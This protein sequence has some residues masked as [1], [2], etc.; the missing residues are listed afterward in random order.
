VSTVRTD[1]DRVPT[2]GGAT[3]EELLEAGRRTLEVEVR[4]LASLREGLG[5]DFLAAVDLL[6]G[7]A[8]RV[9]CTGMGKSGIIAHKLAATLASTGTPALFLHPAEAVHGDLGMITPQDAVLAISNSGETEEVLRMLPVL[10]VMA[11]P[12]V[13]MSSRPESS[14]GRAAE[15][16]LAIPLQEEG[17]PIGLAPMAS[18]TA[19]LALGD[20]L[21]AGLMKR[22]GFQPSDFALFHP[23]GH[24]GRRLLTRVRDLMHPL[25]GEVPAISPATPF[26][27]A[28]E[29]MITSN[30]GA[31][32]VVDEQGAL[33]GLLTDG[34]IK[35]VYQRLGGDQETTVAQ[36]MTRSPTVVGPE[37]M[38]ERAL[39]IMEDRPRQ[40]TVLPVVG[41]DRRALGL[42][43]LHDILRAKIK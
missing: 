43:R 14:L 24:L 19:C 32:L 9:I 40:I 28:L 16:H 12:L 22:R 25:P 10:E 4:I 18:T 23:A 21:A 42:I 37:V 1:H 31:I 26:R 30:M 13:A 3:R 15:V 17:C 29:A 33:A 8:G 34:D 38:A 6:F 36:V 5:E 2:S 27:E 41:E 7:V 35:R 20:A 11:V 39:R